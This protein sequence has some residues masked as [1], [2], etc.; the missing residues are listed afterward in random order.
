MLVC[1]VSS[2][3]MSKDANKDVPEGEETSPGHLGLRDPVFVQ[4]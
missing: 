2:T 4:H 3:S 1:K